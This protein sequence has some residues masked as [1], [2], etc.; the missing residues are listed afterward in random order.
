MNVSLL[1]PRLTTYPE[2]DLLHCCAQTQ[3]SGADEQR[4]RQLVAAE[5][6][7]E[8]LLSQAAYHKVVPLLYRN[9]SKLG[10]AIPAAVLAQLQDWFY[11]NTIH[12][13][14]LTSELLRAI[15]QL[16]AHQI[17]ALP[18][19]GAALAAMAYGDLALRI[20]TDLDLWLSQE[21]FL[22]A[23]SVLVEI[24]YQ[25][26]ETWF[27]SRSDEEI[28]HRLMGEY[29]LLH[30]DTSIELDIHAELAAVYPFPITVDLSCFRERL[31]P[32]SL[33][34]QPVLTFCPE[35]YLLYLC[36]HGCR[37]GWP[38]LYQ[39][40][41][42]RELLRQFPSLDWFQVW[43]EAKRLRI[44]RMV[45]LG[46]GLAQ[47]VFQLALPED[48]EQQIQSD[49][50]AQQLV[51]QLHQNFC[52]LAPAPAATPLSR[53]GFYLSLLEGRP[54]KLAYLT[55]LAGQQLRLLTLANSRDYDFLP[56]PP[57]LYGL[58]YLIRPL[59]ILNQYRLGLLKLLLP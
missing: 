29:S 22:K 41:D 3:L 30:R 16:Q 59:R 31:R 36:L 18:F 33:L 32:V 43:A 13:L 37:D 51:Q 9:L 56:L 35:D 54:A 6:D 40:C 34:D 12:S 1:E 8:V 14:G 21:D 11:A 26:R 28:Y 5:V 47:Q 39:L 10:S 19:K 4:L 49:A 50:I 23:K 7:W 42:L 24:N 17:S 45:R 46:L 44:E 57:P 55:R 20:F 52:T 2:L 58:Y 27:L 53:S 48:V 25:P 38:Y 15:A